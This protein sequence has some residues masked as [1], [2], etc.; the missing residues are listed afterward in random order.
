MKIRERNKPEIF[1]EIRS[2]FNISKLLHAQHMKSIK[3]SVLDGTSKWSAKITIISTSTQSSV[4]FSSSVLSGCWRILPFLLFNE[5][6]I[7]TITHK[8]WLAT[9]FQSIQF[10][11]STNHRESFCHFEMLLVDS[12][13]RH[14][15]LLF[16][17]APVNF[18]GPMQNTGFCDHL[19]FVN[20]EKGTDLQRSHPMSHSGTEVNNHFDVN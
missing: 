20:C 3:Q 15:E 9:F 5:M 11:Q 2:L 6:K 17:S 8:W 14:R 1:E 16:R 7:L 12:A 19:K 18:W 4:D 10:S 13:L